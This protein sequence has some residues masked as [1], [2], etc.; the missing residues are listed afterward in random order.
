MKLSTLRTLNKKEIVDI[1]KASLNILQNSGVKIQSDKVLD[2]LSN[3]RGVIIDKK[4]KIVRFSADI[5]EE[6]IEKSPKCFELYTQDKKKSIIVG[7]E[8]CYLINGHCAAFF[9]DDYNGKRR[10]KKEEVKNFALLSDY[11]NEIDIIGIEGVPQDVEDTKYSFI[12]G[13]KLTLLN[14][15]KPFHY[16]PEF[17]FEN[18]AVL[19]IVKLLSRDDLVSKPSILSQVTIISPLAWPKDI[20]E[21]LLKN[22]M[23]GIP[24]VLVASPYS[25][26]SAP[27]TLAGQIALFN[28][29]LLSGIVIN[30]LANSSSGIVYGCACATFDMKE[31]VANIATPETSIMRIAIAQMADFYNLPSFTSGPDTDSN[32]YDEQNGWEKIITAFTSFSSGLNMIVNGGLFSTGTV[33]SYEQLII[34][35]EIVGYIRRLINGFK[36]NKETLA[37]DI[38]NKVGPLGNFIMEDHTLKNL[39]SGEHW[40]PFISNRM[41]FSKWY[42]NGAKDV[43]TIACEKAKGILKKYKPYYINE[44][45]KIKV[46]DFLI[47]FKKHI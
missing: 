3:F 29:E 45:K 12:E 46:E 37:V 1:H 34:D 24:I 47:N 33:V 9:F 31:S 4:S 28:A 21:I 20:S 23:L 17:N 10:I 16:T 42:S 32:I 19:G 41:M 26:V 38:I 25:G 7:E 6:S 2:F 11:L 13:A 8:N 36:I 43:A 18:E 5:I 44:N 40:V 22:S 39:R 35:S 15:N 30:K 14:S 27:I